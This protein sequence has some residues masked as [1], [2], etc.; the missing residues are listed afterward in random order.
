V[1]PRMSDDEC[2]LF[3]SILTCSMRYLEFGCGGS[4]YVAASLVQKAIISI[5]SSSEWLDKVRQVC[6]LRD[7]LIR[8]TLV[9]VD[10]G[11]TIEWGQPQI[12]ALGIGGP[13][14]M[15][16]SGPARRV[17]TPMFT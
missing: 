9:H 1:T 4:T 14:I 8:P 2:R 5:D 12:L 11:P 10:I 3:K 7:G 17:P 16:V 6:E 15:I 13:I